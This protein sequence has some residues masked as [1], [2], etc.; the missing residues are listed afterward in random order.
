MDAIKQEVKPEFHITPDSD[1]DKDVRVTMGGLTPDLFGFKSDD[2]LYLKIIRKEQSG[3]PQPSNQS[4]DGASAINM[5]IARPVDIL[6]ARSLKD[7]SPHHAS[8]IQSKKFSIM[9]MGF[10]SEGD[11]AQ[12]S[13]DNL[14]TPVGQ[15]QQQL[16][17]LLTGEAYVQTKVDKVINPLTMFG[18]SFELYR[19]IEDFL[20]AGTGYLEVVRD[21]E[22]K[23]IGVNWL[24][25]ED[26][27]VVVIR[28]NE[29]RRRIAY[30]Y[31]GGTFSSSQKLYSLF[32]IANK[33]W[34]YDYVYKTGKTV[35]GITAS[36][37]VDITEISE[38]IPI[39]MPSNQ[40]FY[41]GYPE[42]LAASTVVTLLSR[43]LQYKS[44]FY[45]NKG[46]LAYI[47]S[48]CGSM[49]DKLWEQIVAKIQG[50]VGGGNAF[51]NLAIQL[52]D[53]NAKVQVDKL[54]SSDKTEMQF[55]KDSEAFAQLIVSSHR[56]P[57]VL[58]NILVSGKMGAA[59]ETVQALIAFQLLNVGP[60]Q[61]MIQ[62]I[63]ANTLGKEG[64][65]ITGLKPEDFRLRKITSQ[66]NIQGLD[67][68]SRMREEAPGSGR[69]VSRG[70]KD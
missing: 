28:D 27:E 58:A 35:S 25:Y 6:T 48:V 44:D 38:V 33:K 45:V 53:A 24:P 63:L 61:Q 29:G 36:S 59:N 68:A 57:P 3:D 65:G 37:S 15:V 50:S 49:D 22:S 70:L 8:C 64:D 21:Q 52:S 39:M 1:K 4:P 69:D 56:V 54:A 20:D 55:A 26:I 51:R 47:L 42:W 23:I 30:R 13:R 5:D 10:V 41:Y 7:I 31:S 12:Q 66:F 19:A 62:Q 67:T 11:E 34:L 14:T 60:K 32:G 43:A 2:N 9:G 17:S 46:V 40:S 16:S 18:F